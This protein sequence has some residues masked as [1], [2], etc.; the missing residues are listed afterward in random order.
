MSCVREDLPSAMRTEIS[1]GRINPLFDIVCL[2]LVKIDLF[3]VFSSGHTPA[4]DRKSVK[5]VALHSRTKATSGN[6]IASTLES[7]RSNARS[8]TKDSIKRVR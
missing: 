7:V 5:Y 3:F 1:H 6:T 2:Y 8:A 4:N